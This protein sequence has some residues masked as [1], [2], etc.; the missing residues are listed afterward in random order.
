MPMLELIESAEMSV[1]QLM[2][3]LGHHRSCPA[4]FRCGRGQRAPPGQSERRDRGPRTAVGHR[5]SEELLLERAA[6]SG[7]AARGAEDRRLLKQHDDRHL[8]R[9]QWMVRGRRRSGN[10]NYGRA[11]LCRGGLV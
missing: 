1:Y 11:Y 5:R 7:A 2:T 9:F 3:K 4:D 6:G 8:G 10:R